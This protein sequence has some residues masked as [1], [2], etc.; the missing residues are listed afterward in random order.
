ME[1]STIFNGKIHYFDWAMF[2]CY[3][4]VHQRVMMIYISWGKPRG[5]PWFPPEFRKTPPKKDIW[6]GRKML[7]DFFV[8]PCEEYNKYNTLNIISMLLALNLLYTLEHLH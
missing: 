3:V 6:F 4:N 7:T 1:R 2:N 8:S 5:K